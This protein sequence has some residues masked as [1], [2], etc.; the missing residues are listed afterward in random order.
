[1]EADA[2]ADAADRAGKIV[3]CRQG[4][5]RLSWQVRTVRDIVRSGLLA[6]VYFMRLIG[7]SLYRPGV[8]Y[9]P[10]A[11]WFLDR[12]KAG[13]GALYDWGVYDL[14]ILFSVFGPLEVVHTTAVTFTGVDSPELTTP[15]DV[16]E[17]AA[18]MLKLR[19][20]KAIYWERGWASHLP[21]EHR[22]D[23]YGTKA[24][25]SFVPH[26]NVLGLDFGLRITQYAPGQEVELPMPL[27]ASS[28]PNVYEDFLLAV[29]GERA[30]AVSGRECAAMLRI[31]E[32]VYAS[33]ESAVLAAT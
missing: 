7:R 8:E 27:L 11:R 33:A 23:F 15:F 5:T 21:E 2:M 14:D 9:N 16:E 26:S 32:G 18:A 29:V 22:W 12:S 25:L 20:G 19:D 28:G 31:I 3:A 6:D 4:G 1:V 17:H 24:G 13:G 30:P 10:G